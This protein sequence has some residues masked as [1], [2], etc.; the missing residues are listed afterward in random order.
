MRA[1]RYR[2]AILKAPVERGDVGVRQIGASAPTLHQH[3]VRV[4]VTCLRWFK[5]AVDL[6]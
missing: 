2:Q 3:A 1:G 5:T 6:E 4:L